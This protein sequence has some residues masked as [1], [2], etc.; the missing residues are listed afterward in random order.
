MEGKALRMLGVYILDVR[1][2]GQ[3]VVQKKFMFSYENFIRNRLRELEFVREGENQGT[4]IIFENV[5]R[6]D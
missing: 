1:K 5:C 6:C 4:I 2:P 3:M